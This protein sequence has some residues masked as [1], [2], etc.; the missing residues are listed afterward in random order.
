MIRRLLSTFID[1][2]SH[3]VT[4]EFFQP[5]K[6]SNHRANFFGDE[7]LDNLNFLLEWAPC[8][9]VNG[10]NIKII[11]EPKEFYQSLLQH[12]SSAQK[13]ISLASLYLGVGKLESDLLKVIQ[14][15][16]NQN[17]DLR[18][19]ILLDYTRGTRGKNNSK[20]MI[21]PL[22]KQSDNCN[23]SLYHTRKYK[24][25]NVVTKLTDDYH[26]M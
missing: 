25:A 4:S 14:Q 21:M 24:F 6:V 18:I 2:P 26:S 10:K 8:F 12:A 9:S 15:N 5:N 22:I 20:A 3:H 13:R 23:L 11:S 16:M 17:E 1:Y 7:K 19:N